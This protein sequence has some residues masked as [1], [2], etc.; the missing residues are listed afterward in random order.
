LIG[1]TIGGALGGFGLGIAKW[2][3][4]NPN[5]ISATII[6]IFLGLILGIILAISFGGFIATILNMAENLQKIADNL[7]NHNGNGEAD[8]IE[9]ANRISKRLLKKEKDEHH[10]WDYKK[11]FFNW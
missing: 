8:N 1:C 5:S 4:I 10:P 9:E 2:G 7:T 6:G 3:G 11:G